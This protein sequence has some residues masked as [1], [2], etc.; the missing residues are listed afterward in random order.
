M[1]FPRIVKIVCLFVGL[2]FVNVSTA[3]SSDDAKLRI[4]SDIKSAQSALRNTQST[5]AKEQALLAKKIFNK[6]QSLG[7]LREQA[8][9]VMPLNRVA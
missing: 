4:L 1:A 5:I 2:L 9:L 7:K 8:A 6:Q 3:A